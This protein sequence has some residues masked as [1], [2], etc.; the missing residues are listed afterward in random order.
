MK[1]STLA[2]GALLATPSLVQAQ[3][4]ADR[5]KAVETGLL[6]AV[7]VAGAPSPAR[8]LDEAMR[9]LNVPGVAI[10][11]VRGGKLDWVKG[12][13]MVTPGGAAVGPDTLFQAGSV[14]KPV[15]AVAAMRLVQDGTLALEA[16]I[17]DALKSW[18]LPENDFTRASPVTLRRLLSHT[19]G[20]TVHGFAGYA[21][22]AP[23]PS[24]PQILDGVAPANSAA[25]RV[26]TPVGAAY[27][28]SGGGYTIV[29]QAMIDAAGAPF[30]A[31]A[32]KAVLQPL[33]M[34]RSTYDQPLPA[35]TRDV[36]LAHDG[37][38]QPIAGGPHVYPE[39][40]AAGLWTT[41][42]DL[43]R[44][45]ID[46]QRSAGQ[47]QGKVLS[48][49]TAR[50]M[51]TPEPAG[52]ALGFKII[53]E[54]RDQAFFHDGSNAG[55]KATLIGHAETGDGAVI[56]TNGDQ[57]YQLGK[58]ILRGIAV[59][60]GWPDQRPIT[61]TAVTLPLD[62]QRGF[63]GEFEI[64]GLGTFDIRDGGPAMTIEIRKDQVFKLIPAAAQSFFVVEQDVVVTFDGPDRGTLEA[65]GQR[66]GFARVK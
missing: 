53:G 3:T 56:L 12:Y 24:A 52:W 46:L 1:L 23:L 31:I 63:A 54:G 32:R 21:A 9:A 10:A 16:P 57:G 50:R 5:Q 64:Q 43:A 59:A 42:N 47:D 25:V 15:A 20:T 7:L 41:A 26:D 18:R 6:P 2:L 34:G 36:A 22:G 28:Y 19:A 33:G 55:Y 51:L 30:P 38:G 45:V 40:A 17:N 44:F 61:R 49:A 14:S 4:V 13:G 60:Y 58:D 48:A 39:L 66:F 29:Q 27:R 37:T 8:R 62:A 11:V 65:D 35:G